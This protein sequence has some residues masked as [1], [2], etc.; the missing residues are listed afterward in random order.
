M[1]NIKKK[2]IPNSIKSIHHIYLNNHT[3]IPI[4]SVGMNCLLNQNDI[5]NDLLLFHE[6]SLI[7]IYDFGEH[8]LQS[9]SNYLS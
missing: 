9:I 8:A 5:I 7:I 6:A 4:D 2:G 1:E 3:F